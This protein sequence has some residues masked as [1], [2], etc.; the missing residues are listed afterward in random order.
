MGIEREK[1]A[2]NPVSREKV[3]AG[4]HL[5]RGLKKRFLSQQ[6]SEIP[7]LEIIKADTMVYRDFYTV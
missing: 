2:L 5:D 6:D 3:L 4:S 7:R 1:T